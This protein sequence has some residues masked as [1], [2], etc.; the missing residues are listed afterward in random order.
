MQLPST[1]RSKKNRKGERAGLRTIAA[2][3]NISP[4]GLGKAAQRSE[5]NPRTQWDEAVI[6]RG[7]GKE[8]PGTHCNFI[9]LERAL[10]EQRHWEVRNEL[11]RART[12]D[13]EAK[14][15]KN[16][17]Q[18][19][20]D[21]HHKV[22]GTYWSKALDTQRA[23]CLNPVAVKDWFEIVK[24]EIVEAGVLPE[25]IYAMDESGFPP[26]NQGTQRVVGRAGNRIQHKQGS[27]N[28]E[29]CHCFGNNLR[30][31]NSSPAS[32]GVQGNISDA[33]LD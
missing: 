26:S 30:R 9:G 31:R 7:G 20:K 5:V 13:P 22:I 14:V 32:C 25:N 19:F 4:S 3:Y 1:R 2:K 6:D 16:W 27:A 33:A 24:T 21:R 11:L 12:E 29:K 18:R 28:R 17:V 8:N 15:G 10:E 23:K